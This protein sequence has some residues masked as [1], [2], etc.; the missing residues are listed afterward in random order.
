MA[1]RHYARRWRQS[2]HL[3]YQGQ[4]E[5]AGD[6]AGRQLARILELLIKRTLRFSSQFGTIGF[7]DARV[8]VEY[9]V[10]TSRDGLAIRLNA[11]VVDGSGEPH[12]VWHIIAF[13]RRAF[14]QRKNSPPIRA[15]LGLRTKA[16][17]LE[18]S[19]FPGYRK[20]DVFV[21][22]AGTI[23]RGIEPRKWYE[24]AAKEYPKLIDLPTI[25]TLQL[26]V[27]R[28]RIEKPRN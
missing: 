12:L 24:T 11:M 22:Q 19:R 21:I 1:S 27:V 26:R 7:R 25:R 6:R 5:A 23:V 16:N 9:E 18:V 14:R 28:H 15:R 2:L 17:T 4:L 20:H 3:E 8:D 13:G 10:K